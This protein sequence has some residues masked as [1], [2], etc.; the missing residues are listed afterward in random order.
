MDV[1]SVFSI[2]VSFRSFFFYGKRV[3]FVEI[4]KKCIESVSFL[5]D[6][7]RSCYFFFFG[8]IFVYD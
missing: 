5:F 7:V 4:F 8:V 3:V 1:R 2:W 6:F